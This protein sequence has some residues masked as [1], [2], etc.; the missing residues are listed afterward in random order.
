[1]ATDTPKESRERRDAAGRATKASADVANTSNSKVEIAD[2]LEVMVVSRGFY[3]VAAWCN[4]KKK[5]ATTIFDDSKE[6]KRC[7]V[8]PRTKLVSAL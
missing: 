6:R 8:L 4:E 3:T 7:V 2:V 5:G 1:L